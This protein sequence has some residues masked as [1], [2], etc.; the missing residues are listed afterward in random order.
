MSKVYVSGVLDVTPMEPGVPTH[1]IYNPP[2]GVPTHPIYNPPPGVPTHP[3]AG[4]GEPSHPIY[5]PVDPPPDS[6]LS[7]AHPIY[8]PIYPAHPIAGTGPYPSHPIYTPDKEEMKRRLKVFLEGN[9]P[10][11]PVPTPVSG[12]KPA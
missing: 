10:Q 12:A 6:G 5:I 11:T 7:P 9:L 1:P 2:P 8:I 4:I 3:I